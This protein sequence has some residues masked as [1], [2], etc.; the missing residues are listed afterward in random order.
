MKTN[1]KFT[2]LRLLVLGVLAAGLHAKPASAQSFQ[3]NFTLSSTAHWGL[4]TLPAG[5]YSF[6]LN[7]QSP[8]SM[9][10]VTRGTENVA[11]IATRVISNTTSGRSE[12]IVENGNVR[13]LSL[14]QIGVTLDY[15][16]H[17]AGRRAA[18]REPQLAQIIPVTT[19]GAGR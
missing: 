10:V 14:P 6:T 9:I 16:G 7:H 3:G 12:M 4:A 2:V 1:H 18:P 13:K 5:D 8:G 19:T 17:G 15:P 11:L